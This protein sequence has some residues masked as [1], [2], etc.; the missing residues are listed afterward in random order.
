MLLVVA[1]MH[2]DDI[3]QTN[4]IE[5]KLAAG[6]V[7]STAYRYGEMPLPLELWYEILRQCEVWQLGRC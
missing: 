6:I 5:S 4:T 3:V 2:L 1:R 7:D